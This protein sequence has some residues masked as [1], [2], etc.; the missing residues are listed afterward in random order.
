MSALFQKLCIN[1]ISVLH[2][3]SESVWKGEPQRLFVLFDVIL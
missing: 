1:P 2:C 3:K